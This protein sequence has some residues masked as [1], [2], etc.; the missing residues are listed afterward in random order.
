MQAEAGNV[1]TLSVS[2]LAILPLVAVHIPLVGALVVVLVRKREKIRDL[3]ALTTTLV[4]TAVIASTYKIVIEGIQVGNHYFRS[5]EFVVPLVLQPGVGFRIDAVSFV[6]AIIT[7]I[8]WS[9][10]LIY[11]LSYMENERAK[12]FL[13]CFLPFDSLRQ[14]W[15]SPNQ[16]FLF[17]VSFL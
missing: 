2:L 7:G 15:S 16:G 14:S 13:L 9:L 6:F 11:S 10:A 4:T 8:V 3:A 17:F 12:T 1:L 5:L